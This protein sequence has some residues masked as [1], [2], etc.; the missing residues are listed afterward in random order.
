MITILWCVPRSVSTAFEKMMWCSEK[1][2]V[3]SEPFLDL[4]KQSKLSK[5]DF[6]QAKSKVRAIC[7]E[8]LTHSH[9]KP[10]FVKEMAYHAEPFITDEFIKQTTHVFL[11]RDPVLSIPSLYKMRASYTE[12]QPG[13]EGSVALYDRVERLVDKS[14][15]IID[16]Q[17]LISSPRTIVQ[18]YF[19][20]LN[21]EMPDEVLSWQA[22]SRSEWKSRE[23]WHLHA[24][25]SQGFERTIK[26]GRVA[27]LPD[28]VSNSI[29]RNTPLYLKMLAKMKGDK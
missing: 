13:F 19:N 6:N 8:L 23:S 25:N 5:N 11:I 17:E 4:Y 22:G 18:S 12:D 29:D 26:S 20:Y 28:K 1:F 2:D 3:V 16:A 21:M 10:V 15:I 9:R 24:I 27:D 14:P 7:A